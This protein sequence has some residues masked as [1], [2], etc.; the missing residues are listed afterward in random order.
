MSPGPSYVC[1]TSDQPLLYRS[2]AGVLGDAAASWPEVPALIVR[3][4]RIRW[5]YAEL[6]RRVEQA[7]RGLQALGLAPGDRVGIW[8]P[9][10]A[11]WV[12][13]Q[14]A[15]ARAGLILVNINPAY[16]S[17]EL[18]YA[19][20]KVGCR[21]L[22]LAPSFKSSDYIQ[23]LRSL[24]PSLA[25]PG[26]TPLPCPEFPELEILIHLGEDET[27]GMLRFADLQRLGSESHSRPLPPESDPDEP[28]NIQFTSGTTGPPKGATLSH[29]N[30]VNNGYFVARG[31]SIR[32]GERICVPVP[33][34]HC[35]GMVMGV[36][37]AVTHGATVVFPS[38]SFD[39]E[40]VLA[41]IAEERCTALYGVPTMFIAELEHPRFRQFDL[42][43][44]RTGIMAGAPC[45][46]TVMRRVISEMHMEQVTI[47]YGMTETSPVS[48]Q[49]GIHDPLDKRVGTVGRIHPHVQVK[50]IDAEGKIVP[51]GSRGELCTRGYNVMRGYWA[52]PAKTAESIDDSGWM[53]T[54]DLAVLD[55]EGYCSIVGRSKDMIIRGGEN[56]YPRELEEFLL[57]HPKVLDVAV[58]GVPDPK[59][60]E[61]VCAVIRQRE[62]CTEEEILEFCREQIAHYKVPRFVRFVESFPMTVTGKVQKFLIREQQARELNLEENER[63]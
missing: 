35:F 22:I 39:A 23:I 5:T 30:I 31:M 55:E 20:R 4:Q 8:S 62:Q 29:F 9:N 45:P 13:T 38:E 24:I 7:A 26:D 56:I 27:P 18:G 28:V 43:S 19:L 52:D 53:H 60:G 40:S 36:L 21:A 14:F 59:Y 17:A 46:I 25:E 11:Q 41:A 1:G 10:N 54:G 48:F 3:H 63:S 49:S 16:R 32:P 6:H 47:C 57:R 37:G 34:Y 44:L 50:L 42:T 15:T 2:V 12:V 33:L 51:R 61:V 58:V